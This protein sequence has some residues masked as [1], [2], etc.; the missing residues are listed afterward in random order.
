M[1]LAA[2]ACSGKQTPQ[3]GCTKD[4]DCRDPRVCDRGVC[5]DPRP[6]GGG[7]TT[8]PMPPDAAVNTNAVAGSPPFA[9][10]GGDARHTGRRGGP[11]PA[12]APKELWKVPVGGVV[13]GS[14]TIGP[15]GTIYVASHVG[16]L[17]AVDPAGTVRW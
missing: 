4:T 9:M 13:V 14:P 7:A 11:A 1:V 2:V 10:F 6:S 16:N 17:S 8:I 12:R 3:A 15:D 5:I